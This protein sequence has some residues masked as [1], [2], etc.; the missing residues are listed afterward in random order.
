MERT[1][2]VSTYYVGNQEQ[3]IEIANEWN[4]LLNTNEFRSR[5]TRNPDVYLI[6]G[7]V[8]KDDLKKVPVIK[9]EFMVHK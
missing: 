2:E 3:A 6:M 7:L 1:I 9:D 5:T 8:S 4:A